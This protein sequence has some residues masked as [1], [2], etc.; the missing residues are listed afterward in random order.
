MAR[1]FSS[2]KIRG[3]TFFAQARPDKCRRAPGAGGDVVWRGAAD[4]HGDNRPIHEDDSASGPAKA[5][6]SSVSES[7]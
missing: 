3:K 7:K 5:G 4:E 6:S 1:F 2:V